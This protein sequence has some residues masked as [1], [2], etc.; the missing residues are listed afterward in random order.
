MASIE[1]LRALLAQASASTLCS[2]VTLEATLYFAVK[3]RH[4]LILSIFIIK[5]QPA[6]S[7]SSYLII[8]LHSASFRQE[9]IARRSK[10]YI[11]YA[12]ELIE[13]RIR[14]D[15]IILRCAKREIIITPDMPWHS[16]YW[17][18]RWVWLNIIEIPKMKIIN[19]KYQRGEASMRRKKIWY[20]LYNSHSKWNVYGHRPP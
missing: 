17:C 2:A 16:A 5:S 9:K 12:G 4:A 10:Y 19:I 11:Y 1:H 15:A 6:I 7:K 8:N 13:G 18:V 14:S 3:R 20:R